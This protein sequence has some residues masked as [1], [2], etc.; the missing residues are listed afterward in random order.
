MTQSTKFVS[1]GKLGK[2]RGVRGE[3]YVT[4]TTDFPD[5]FLNLKEIFTSDRSDWVLMRIES[6]RMI[7][8][9]PVL[10][11]E[12][13]ESKEEAARLTNRELAVTRDQLVELPENS[14]YLF[15][16]VGCT[17]IDNESR[18]KLGTV[19]DVQQYPAND[20][21][22]IETEDGK[23]ALIPAVKEFVIRVDIENK[24][25]FVDRAGMLTNE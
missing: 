21:Y 23:E 24:T 5:R 15:D 13:I 10:K 14:Y 7:S 4:P 3:I 1:V 16:L 9:R 8:G 19:T 18:K 25:V 20:V 6:S 2:T 22:L 12:G 11:F 17:V